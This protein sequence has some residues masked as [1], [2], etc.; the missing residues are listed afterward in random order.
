MS[1][2][3]TGPSR[4]GSPQPD[5]QEPSSQ[6]VEPEQG[7]A[8]SSPQQQGFAQADPQ[9]QGS[10]Q[11]DPQEQ[12]LQQ[13]GF[14]HPDPSQQGPSQQDPPRQGSPLPGWMSPT[15]PVAPLPPSAQYQAQP[16]AAPQYAAP[17]DGVAPHY[18][19]AQQYG[20]TPQYGPGQY[21]PAQGGPAQYGPGQYG[22]APANPAQYGPGQNGPGQYAAGQYGAGQYGPG[23][24]GA[25]PGGPNQY[26]PPPVWQWSVG[27]VAPIPPRLPSRVKVTAIALLACALAAGAGGM[28]MARSSSGSAAARTAGLAGQD[29]AVRALWRT[30]S[31]NDL[32]PLS[33]SREGTET[34]QRIGVDPIEQCSVLPAPMI[35]A[36]QPA[37]CDRV[38]EATYV[39]RTQ[40]VTATVGIVLLSGSPADR[41]AVLKG[42]TA[43]AD[44]T[45]TAMM[46]FT[47]PI[48]G[49]AAAGFQNAQ[50]VT[51]QSQVSDD[52]TY[53]VY[54]V[55]GF[56]DGRTGPAATD[57]A[58]GTGT[59]LE[60]DSPPVQVA[61][62]LP[63]AI[64]QILAARETAVL[65][66]SGS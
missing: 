50:R 36:L 63:A 48:P 4:S 61:A 47:Y 46:P 24:Y 30:S 9:Q 41:A 16:Y 8:Q 18:G 39:D 23:Q 53:L 55:T 22:P 14:A 58:T 17:R 37:G 45:N 10:T 5:P 52:G 57:R 51:W 60:S 7:P 6:Q 33:L 42:W 64:Q 32:L 31:A 40:T 35:A 3:G 19:P 65:G 34:Y 59:A 1:T 28:A 26:G 15:P 49:T 13:Q 25:G 12:S 43:D 56:T 21:G 66:T 11:P 2:D 29:Q 54:A 27:Q 44:A 38:I 62:D 20:P